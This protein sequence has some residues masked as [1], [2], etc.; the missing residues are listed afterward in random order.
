MSWETGGR[1]EYPQ[2]F[3]LE[4]IGLYDTVHVEFPKM[5]VSATATVVETVRD[6][7]KDRFSSVVIGNAVKNISDVIV[8]QSK[9]IYRI[10]AN[11]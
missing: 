3:Y 4:K 2:D 5:G 6:V 11:I 9:E 8:R 7:L 1:K 10:K